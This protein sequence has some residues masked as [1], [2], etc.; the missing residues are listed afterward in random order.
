MDVPFL[1]ESILLHSVDLLSVF[2]KKASE[3]PSQNETKNINTHNSC[4]KY[5]GC[6]R[7]IKMNQLT[8]LLLNFLVKLI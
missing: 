3:I 5:Q 7:E 4:L 2:D 8:F 6:Q 1:G